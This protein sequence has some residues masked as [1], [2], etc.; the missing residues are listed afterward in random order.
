MIFEMK[1]WITTVKKPEKISD[2]K[3]VAKIERRSIIS[4][5]LKYIL[6]SAESYFKCKFRKLHFSAPVKL[7]NDF[8]SFVQNEVFKKQDG[9]SVVSPSES[10]DEGI[11]IIYDHI[12][13]KIIN[14]VKSAENP[15][16]ET[17][18]NILIIDCGGSTTDLASCYY[19][20]KRSETGFN[21]TLR[22][23][24]ENG[25]SNFGG[26]NLTYRIFQLLK[27]KLADYYKNNAS[28]EAMNIELNDLISLNQNEIFDEV[29]M[30]IKNSVPMTIYNRL[31]ERSKACEEILPT[32][33]NGKTWSNHSKDRNL[34]RRNFYYLWQL[35]EK[36]KIKFFSK[37][38]VV[39][40]SF[41]DSPESHTIQIDT[42]NL[43]FYIRNPEGNLPILKATCDIPALRPLPRISVDINEINSLLRPDIYYLLASVLR[44]DPLEYDT[45]KLSGQSCMINLFRDLLKEFVPGYKLR[46]GFLSTESEHASE[47]LKMNCVNGCVEYN[48]DRDFHLINATIVPENQNII[49]DVKIS[50]GNSSIMDNYLFRGSDYSY[51]NNMYVTKPIHIEQFDAVSGHINISVYNVSGIT[52]LEQEFSYRLVVNISENED[53]DIIFL[54]YTDTCDTRYNILKQQLC[55][56]SYYNIDKYM[57]VDENNNPIDLNV[58]DDLIER[59]RNID[60]KPDSKK[61]LVFSVPNTDGYGFVLYQIVKAVNSNGVAK[62]YQTSWEHTPFESAILSKSFFNGKNCEK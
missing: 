37:S 59:I 29:D 9:F 14:S 25:N 4:A 50:R 61:L 6:S 38:D 10:I 5:Y 20:Y 55:N 49:Y 27:I 57:V 12:S 47:K 53:D 16:A 56:Y 35:A 23:K 51:K 11:A 13:Q 26:N 60:V 42:K 3:T 44:A 36:L 32:D 62:Y 2:G 48:N 40:V 41:L 46:N 45:I 19:S 33:F 30:C 31:D 58:V 43:Y 54:D 1:R 15:D 21:L 18:E 8:I 39:Y 24:F 28:T 22:T 7:K 34:V 17:S 52:Q